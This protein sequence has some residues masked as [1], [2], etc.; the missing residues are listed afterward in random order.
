MVVLKWIGVGLLVLVGLIAGG[1]GIM[2]AVYDWNDARDWL[3]AQASDALGREVRIEGDLHVGLGDPIRIHVEGIKV[4]NEP[5]GEEPTFAELDALDAQLRLWPLLRGDIELPEIRL[6]RPKLALEKNPE[7]AN[8]WTFASGDPRGRVAEEATVPDDRREVPII[9]RLVV[10]EGRLRYR[11]PTSDVD[12]DSNLS[13][14]IGGSGEERVRLDGKGSFAGKP[15]TVTFE[16]G[17]LEYLRDDPKPYPLRVE[18]AVGETRAKVEGSI[19]EPVKLEGVDLS[20]ELRGPDLAEIFPIVGI[21]TPKTRPYTLTGHLTRAGTVWTMEGMKGTVGE[22]D[23]NGMIAVD[24]GG[25]RPVIRGDLTSE[26]LAA[27]DLA[28]FVGASPR[29]PSDYE[30]KARGRIIPDTKVDLE[31]LRFADMDVR[32]RG[33]RVEAPY[34]PM[35]DL[36]T[37]IRLENG[38]ATIDPLKLGVADGRI[39]GTTVLDGSGEVAALD[40]NLGVAGLKLSAFFRDTPFARDMGGIIAGRIQLKGRGAT[41]ADI[42]GSADG[43]IGLAVDKGRVTSLAEAGMKTNVLETLG[44]VLSGDQPVRFN[45]LVADLGVRDGV[46]TSDAIVLDTPETLVI[47]TGTVN[48]KKETLDLTMR[49]D[50]KKAQVGATHVPVRIRGSFLDP[51]IGID[52]TETAARGAA[53]VALGALLTPF[54]AIVPLLDPGGAES[55]NCAGL[56]D[57]ARQPAA[58]SGSSR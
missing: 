4:A 36:D 45:C 7:G 16:G 54:A 15:F 26:R 37:R 39:E 53:A 41:V 34:V 38:R 22:S 14:A 24:L 55:A 32:F 46:M 9:E 40:T 42:A 56:I 21:P 43:K 28:G 49:G 13:T 25:Q 11:D 35:D 44:I 6:T 31:R 20:V 10:E 18:A 19:A 47:G 1:I 27:V 48:L 33:K 51:D 58:A 12:V 52:A 3:A 8:N 57:K 2:A 5:W 29:G 50:G 23:L 30:T 17:S